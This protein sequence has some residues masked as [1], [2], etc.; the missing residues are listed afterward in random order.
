MSKR[1]LFPLTDAEREALD[2]ITREVKA[3]AGA[4]RR[5]GIL[6]RADEAEGWADVGIA[7]AF[8]VS[9][10]KGERAI[11][12]STSGVRDRSGSRSTRRRRTASWR[13]TTR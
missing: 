3:N 2:Q 7:R 1:Y 9:A 13:T 4:F 10:R 12:S 11:S 6:P 8:G 5:A